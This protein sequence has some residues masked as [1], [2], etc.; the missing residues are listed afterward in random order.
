MCVWVCVGWFASEVGVEL[1]GW[2]LVG[3]LGSRET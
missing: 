3:Q 1:V 2:G